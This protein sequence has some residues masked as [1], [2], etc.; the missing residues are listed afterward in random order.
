MKP[1]INKIWYDRR[2]VA[3]P[4][5]LCR[6]E[7]GIGPNSSAIIGKG[8]GCCKLFAYSNA[9]TAWLRAAKEATR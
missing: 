3:R 5:W 6:V 4:Q 8:V 2:A 7:G 1:S 9:K